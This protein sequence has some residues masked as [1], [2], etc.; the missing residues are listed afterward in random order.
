MDMMQQHCFTEMKP[1]RPLD[2]TYFL[3][4]KKRRKEGDP[5]YSWRWRL[6]GLLQMETGNITSITA[7]WQTLP[8]KQPTQVL[9]E[10]SSIRGIQQFQHLRRLHQLRCVEQAGHTGFHC[11]RSMSKGQFSVHPMSKFTTWRGSPNSP[12]FR[13]SATSTVLFTSENHHTVKYGKPQSSYESSHNYSSTWLA[14]LMGPNSI[15]PPHQGVFPHKF[16]QWKLG[17]ELGASPP[18]VGSTLVAWSPAWPPRPEGAAASTPP[19]RC[20]PQ[21][22]RT[23]TAAPGPMEVAI[24]HGKDHCWKNAWSK[25]SCKEK[26]KKHSHFHL[27]FL[28]FPTVSKPPNPGPHL[29]LL[30]HFGAL[31]CN[32]QGLHQA[33]GAEA[34]WRLH[35]DAVHGAHGAHGR[36]ARAAG[37]RGGHGGSIAGS[38]KQRQGFRAIPWFWFCEELLGLLSVEMDE[39]VV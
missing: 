9:Q 12:T 2:V 33:L 16:H 29:L 6:P 28:S 34:P 38:P 5:S 3:I 7:V 31:P 18:P 39:H 24:F 8:A 30:S 19:P 11:L 4:E 13:N 35:A 15:P 37:P 36:L 23:P 32:V 21:K 27:P 14:T 26:Q 1:F 22:R 10:R 20:G 25:W 17:S